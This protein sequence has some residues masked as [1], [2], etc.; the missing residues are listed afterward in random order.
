[1]DR[2]IVAYS[3][4]A[5]IETLGVAGELIET[6]GAVSREVAEAMAVGVRRLAGTDLGLSTT[7][8]AGPSGATKTKPV[9]LVYVGLAHAGGCAV[10][11][12]V[13]GGSREIVKLRA[14]THALDMIR[15]HLAGREV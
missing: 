10:S 8:I 6:H 11:E 3:N 2:G 1:L 5:K 4:E 9:G 7:G 15:I 12:H 14:A 13:F